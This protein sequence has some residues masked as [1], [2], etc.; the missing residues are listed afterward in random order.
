MS[1][2]VVRVVGAV[3]LAAPIALL[4]LLFFDLSRV[5]AARLS[6]TFFLSPPAALAQHAGLFPALVGSALLVTLCGAIAVPTAIAAAIYLEEYARPTRLTRLVAANIDT[7][8][9]VP[10]VVYGLVGLLLFARTLALGRSLLSGA[11]TLALLVLPL[12]V[13][14]T[15]EALRQVPER[16]RESAFALGATKLECVRYVVLPV[17]LPHIATGVVLALSRA[18]GE[19]APLLALTGIAFV[20]FVPGTLMSPITAL[21]LQLFQWLSRPESAF[22]ANTAAAVLTLLFLVF[23]LNAAAIW[24]RIR[25]ERKRV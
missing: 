18:L 1:D 21:P 24:L 14:T 6:L 9:G 4:L 2:R 17:A 5:A 12:I 7:L 8:A 23:L 13:V 11:A 20:A 22:A 16:L 25:A 3:L 15:R 10:S 19:A